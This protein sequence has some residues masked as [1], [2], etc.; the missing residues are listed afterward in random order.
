[1]NQW[2]GA[3]PPRRKD[4]GDHVHATAQGVAQIAFDPPATMV[5]QSLLLDTD[6]RN[7]VLLPITLV[8]VLV[9]IFRNNLM[10]LFE[11]KPKMASL[12]AS[13]QQYVGRAFLFVATYA[14]TS[15]GARRRC[16]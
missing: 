11:S 1:M 4:G 7:W 16:V 13:R 12:A 8:M 6:L 9:G 15:S 3:P 5:K 10:Q 2:R 14:E